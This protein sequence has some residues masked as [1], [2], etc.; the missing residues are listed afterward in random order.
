MRLGKMTAALLLLVAAIL[1][2]A[3]AAQATT[4]Q[5]AVSACAPTAE[6]AWLGTF[7]GPHQWTLSLDGS[8]GVSQIQVEVFQDGGQLKVRRNGY[9]G[10]VAT[11]G[12][13]LHISENHPILGLETT[14]A[15]CGGDGAVAAFSGTWFYH[16]FW[17]E[18]WGCYYWG[19]FDVTRV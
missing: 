15:T 17:P 5:P 1:V 14:S 4:G 2:P 13:L 6:S 11:T 7:S 12:G 10:W 8:T 16:Y 3:T 9:V 18:C 19:T